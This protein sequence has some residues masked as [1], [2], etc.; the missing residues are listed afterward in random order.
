MGLLEE[1]LEERRRL[2]EEEY[3]KIKLKS[4]RINNMAIIASETTGQGFEPISEGVHTA[5]C[6]AVIA[7]GMQYSE[8]FKK[9]T[10]KVMIVWDLPDE[11]YTNKDGEEK[12]RQLHREYTLSLA[13]KS[14]LRKD[15][16]AWRGKAFTEEELGAFDLQNILGAGCQ[17]QVI[18]A[19]GNGKTYANIASIMGLPKGMKID[20]P[21]ALIYFD[22]GDPECFNLINKIPNWIQE[23][24]IKAE[25]YNPP[26]FF[27]VNA[28]GLELPFK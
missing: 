3:E 22:L 24:I 11:V 27:P 2:E 18:H 4:R 13:S 9:S 21:K 26:S 17:I 7:L 12:A 10:D 6:T 15:L 5:V 19:E 20:K 25:N 8:Q 1:I 28:E 14:T 23:K 16:Q